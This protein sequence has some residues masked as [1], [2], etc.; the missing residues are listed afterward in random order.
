M[1]FRALKHL[2]RHFETLYNMQRAALIE[3]VSELHSNSRHIFDSAQR[4]ALGNEDL[5]I[6]TRP[7]NAIPRNDRS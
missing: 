2:T 5:A 7:Q 3:T 1:N 6:R 4:L